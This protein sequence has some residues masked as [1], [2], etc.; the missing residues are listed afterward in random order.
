MISM[1]TTNWCQYKK[2]FFVLPV[3]VVAVLVS[4]QNGNAA[5]L[6]QISS[7]SPPPRYKDDLPELKK[8]TVIRALVT[9]SKSNFFIY[10]GE[11]KGTSYE[12]MNHYEEFLNKGIKREE[13]KTRV[14]FIPV[15]FDQLLTALLE[16]RGDIATAT[17][18][19]TPERAKLVDMVTGAQK[20]SEL[21]VSHKSVTG[22]NNL[23]DLAGKRVYVLKSSSYAEHLRALNKKFAAKN[24]K[25]IKIEE[26]DSHFLTEDILEMVNA[27]VIK[28]TV[29]DD[30]KV[31]HWA[32]V[33]TDLVVHKKIAVS[34]NNRI[35]VAVRKSNPELR[36]SLENF[37][38]NV[39][40][41]SLLGNMIFNRYYKDVRWIKNPVSDAERKKFEE[42]S[43]LFKKYSDQYGFD[44][45]MITAQAY[46][47]SQLDH[48]RKSTAGA[49]GIMQ[50]LKSTAKD[51]VVGVPNI[52]KLE[53]NIH[54]GVKYMAF[55]R[56]RYYSKSD[57]ALVDRVAFTWASYNA[58]PGRV[59]QMRTMAEKMG[60]NPDIWF[61]HVELAAGKIVG[62]ETVKYVSNIYKYYIAYKLIE[63]L[64]ADT[65]AARTKEIKSPAK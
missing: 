21:V 34:E 24:L 37:A 65:E 39:R 59:R 13:Q 9:Y 27:G 45:L 30:F 6:Q 7:A 43:K 57:L 64:S 4:Q 2:Y 40:K 49:I 15:P 62:R 35:G 44:Y 32:K 20:V 1:S 31:L 8:R 33:L 36:K 47:E 5:E 17:L 61:N 12:V 16:G 60:L 11:P 14:V 29:A 50:V 41:G 46:Q 42:T 54:A 38:S 23:E 55:M 28:I 18:T 51:P 52:E 56:D 63:K 26:A 48:S 58:G 10:K 19:K 53:D 25:P 22:L 3:I